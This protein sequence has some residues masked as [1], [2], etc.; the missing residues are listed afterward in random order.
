MSPFHDTMWSALP[1]DAL[2]TVF[3]CL[4]DAHSRRSCRLV[5]RSWLQAAGESP[6]IWQNV[7][8]RWPRPGT[9]AA[10]AAAVEQPTAEQLAA[11][12][13][14]QRAHLRRLQLE[15]GAW[16][17]G[18]STDPAETLARVLAAAC[19]E[20]SGLTDIT[21]ALSGELPDA[22]MRVS[23][24]AQPGMR[25]GGL[26]L[27][28]IIMPELPGPPTL[29]QAL[30]GA[31]QQ[32]TSLTLKPL[33]K[34]LALR[35]AQLGAGLSQLAKLTLTASLDRAGPR[36]G[37]PDAL[38]TLDG[39]TMLRLRGL[40]A[41]ATLPELG[42][43]GVLL[44]VPPTLLRLDL[45]SLDL[46]QAEPLVVAVHPPA[47]GVPEAIGAAIEAGAAAAEALAQQ[48]SDGSG[49]GSSEDEGGSDEDAASSSSGGSHLSFLPE[50]DDIIDPLFEAEYEAA[51]EAA[52]QRAA[53]PLAARWQRLEHLRLHDC[54][55][56]WTLL[57]GACAASHR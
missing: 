22:V 19:S 51:S 8:R 53:A 36:A 48:L 47:P 39:L 1:P 29:A 50:L 21:L 15:Q 4:P 42:E 7:Q 35:W 41:H 32:L 45:L 9:A 43:Q 44:A 30:P 18:D 31:A 25:C 34:E 40:A 38:S 16:S 46:R 5:C 57:R 26:M 20:G 3:G 13:H 52:R 12:L 17:V 27:A 14:R 6:E 55:V 11:L 2:R 56:G 49:S 23:A 28:P 10:S 37:P 33:R 54:H 24:T